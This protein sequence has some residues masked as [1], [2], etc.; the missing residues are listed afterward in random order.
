[1]KGRAF[2][3][4]CNGVAREQN[5]VTQDAIRKFKWPDPV[6]EAACHFV[7]WQSVR[8]DGVPNADKFNCRN[9]S[10]FDLIIARTT[11]DPIPKT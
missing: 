6:A 3:V 2:I 1:M 7:G 10:V 9:N 5:S 4:Q 11:G 8:S